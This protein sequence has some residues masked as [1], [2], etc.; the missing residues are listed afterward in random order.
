M[1]DER[2]SLPSVGALLENSEIRALLDR[3][4][5]TVVVDAIR[6]TIDSA[7]SSP[8]LA[9]LDQR[10]WA[11]AIVAAVEASTVPS[12]R[13]V[14]NGTGVV[15]HTNL[16]RAPLPRVAIDAIASVASGFSN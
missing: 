12:L 14:M 3:T 16:G 13:R 11:E 5:R 15:L 2:R 1:S 8:T 6:R 9:P 7:R 10:A 4:P